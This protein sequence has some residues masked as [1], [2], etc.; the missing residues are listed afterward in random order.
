MDISKP[1][2]PSRHFDA[3]MEECSGRSGLAVTF[4]F[5]D[6]TEKHLFLLSITNSTKD[7]VGKGGNFS[8]ADSL[9]SLMNVVVNASSVTNFSSLRQCVQIAIQK[10]FHLV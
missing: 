9:S 2:G 8:V 7:D 4:I 1:N 5:S 10:S 3:L 6:I